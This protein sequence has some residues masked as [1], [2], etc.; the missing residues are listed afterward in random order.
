MV[1]WLAIPNGYGSTRALI[2]ATHRPF[3]SII[4]MPLLWN[5]DRDREL[6]VPALAALGRFQAKPAKDS[7]K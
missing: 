1:G 3:G 5:R 7:G 2:A 6:I 4:A